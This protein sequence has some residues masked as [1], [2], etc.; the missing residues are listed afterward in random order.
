M[1]RHGTK[2]EVAAHARMN[3]FS[4]AD[5]SLRGLLSVDDVEGLD[6]GIAN[7]L[8]QRGEVRRPVE[9]VPPNL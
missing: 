1:L 6:P 9:R 2:G 4:S 5:N 8:P 7:Y 3:P